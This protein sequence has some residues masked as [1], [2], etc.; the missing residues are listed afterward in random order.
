MYITAGP[1]ISRKT[2]VAATNTPI[3]D[4]GGTP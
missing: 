4:A 3:D 2:N 1:G